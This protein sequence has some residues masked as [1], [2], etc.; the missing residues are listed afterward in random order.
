MAAAS[1]SGIL[2]VCP[3]ESFSLSAVPGG[4]SAVTTYDEGDSAGAHGGR[5]SAESTRFFIASRQLHAST[6]FPVAGGIARPPP[7]L[8]A[9]VMPF[10]QESAREAATWRALSVNLDVD[11]PATNGYSPF[12]LELAHVPLFVATFPDASTIVASKGVVVAE[13]VSDLSDLSTRRLASRSAWQDADGWL[14]LLSPYCEGGD[15]RR[16]IFQDRE[17]HRVDP[18]AELGLPRR[19]SS[20]SASDTE[21]GG[22]P[23]VVE[24]STNRSGGV[25]ELVARRWVAQL[26]HACAA[27][28][29]RGVLHLDVKPS[30]VFLTSRRL[31]DADVRLGDFGLALPL[32]PGRDPATQAA[33]FTESGTPAYMSPER[34]LPPYRAGF[35]AVVWAVGAIAV[36]LLTGVD[37]FVVYRATE[38]PPLD[39][40]MDPRYPLG[41][42]LL[43]NAATLGHAWF[44]GWSDGACEFV[45]A[46]TAPD[47]AKRPTA[48]AAL[49][50]LQWVLDVQGVSKALD[51]EVA[52]LAPPDVLPTWPPRQVA[53]GESPGGE[54]KG[55][56]WSLRAARQHAV[57]WL[58][59]RAGASD[60]RLAAD[61]A[62]SVLE[63]LRYRAQVVVT[64]DPA[65]DAKHLR[66]LSRLSIALARREWEACVLDQHPD[67][68]CRV[69]RT[70][71][72]LPEADVRFQRLVVELAPFAGETFA[73]M[74][75]RP[76]SDVGAEPPAVT[77]ANAAGLLRLAAFVRRRLSP[78]DIAELPRAMVITA[79]AAHRDAA[80]MRPFVHG[81]EATLA[82]WF[83]LQAVADAVGLAFGLGF[84]EVTP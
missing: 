75:T 24:C 40:M 65:T 26:L 82:L 20:G 23:P 70:D 8:M 27:L 83:P 13:P 76:P 6:S 11:H 51:A 22:A 77:A 36:E 30:N 46:T 10:C 84:M 21:E 55:G 16:I 73:V 74:V 5:V 57:A 50:S 80:M 61:G 1:P 29:A 37:W 18:R 25:S 39:S 31:A 56:E 78:V 62:A 64:S 3:S 47:P 58:A 42:L 17:H 66:V 68:P 35:S 60:G 48:S 19:S 41:P 72:A 45:G 63:L 43:P 33:T 12:L 79:K 67:A 28:E 38:K 14:V 2:L 53:T 71:T 81:A 54:D 59:A 32:G 69:P 52:R 44:V 15:M 9:K 49:E 34:R 7:L 4:G